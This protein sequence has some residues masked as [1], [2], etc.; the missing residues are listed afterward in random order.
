MKFYIA[1]DGRA[2]FDTDQASVLETI[3]ERF[4]RADW[5]MWRDHDAVLVEYEAN[6]NNELTDERVVGHWRE[7]F[8]AL[9]AKCTAPLRG[10]PHE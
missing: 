7:G 5:R 9:R 1:Y 8:K 4:T 10:V 2:E 6:E 3:G